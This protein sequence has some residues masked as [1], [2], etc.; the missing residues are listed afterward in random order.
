MIT[1]IT[2]QVHHPTGLMSTLGEAQVQ[3]D[4]SHEHKFGSM[5]I[6]YCFLLAMVRFYLKKV[7]NIKDS[8]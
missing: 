6:S 7:A 5:V 3:L 1:I 8:A 4:P 2:V